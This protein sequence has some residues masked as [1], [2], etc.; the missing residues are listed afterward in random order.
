MAIDSKGRILAVER[1]CTDPG[2]LAS[3]PAC[4]EPTAVTVLA[5][6]RKVLADNFEGKPLGRVNDLVVD[7]RGGAYF[8]SGGAF[9]ASPAG[10][11]T[12]LGE[13]IR[14][15][16]IMLSRDEKIVYV[17]NGAVILAFD[18]AGWHGHEPA[19]LR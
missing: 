1:T 14:A 19:G 6:E 5:P 16:G 9:Y 8:T 18:P 11:V 13:D 17:T 10:R 15:N 12:S 3:A 2:R 7:R 4:A